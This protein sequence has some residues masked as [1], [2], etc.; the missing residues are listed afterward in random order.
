MTKFL[1]DERNI[2]EEIWLRNRKFEE[3]WLFSGGFPKFEEW[4]FSGG[5]PNSSSFDYFVEAS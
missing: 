5:F 2:F 3:F 1:I 4:L